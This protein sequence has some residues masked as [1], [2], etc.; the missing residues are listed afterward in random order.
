MAG[1]EPASVAKDFAHGV[2][3][4]AVN[5]LYLEAANNEYIRQ[6]L[7]DEARKVKIAA[8][9]TIAP[10]MPVALL[11][12]ELE[13]RGVARGDQPRLKADLVAR[14]LHELS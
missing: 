1:P 3:A 13:E 12:Q 10:K 9:P 5:N 7:Q 6:M 8:L 4:I 14:L 11:R 2:K